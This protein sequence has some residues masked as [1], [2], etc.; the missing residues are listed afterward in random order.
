MTHIKE[1][2]HKVSMA[3]VSSVGEP[4]GTGRAEGIVVSL[5]AEFIGG[6]RDFEQLVACT[7]K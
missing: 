1:R 7:Y 5:V 6:T 2:V 3:K 4:L